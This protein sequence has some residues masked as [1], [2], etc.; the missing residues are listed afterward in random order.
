MRGQSSH[1]FWRPGQSIGV[2]VR[3]SVGLY[4]LRS[5]RRLRTGDEP[6][7]TAGKKTILFS[8]SGFFPSRFFPQLKNLKPKTGCPIGARQAEPAP[9]RTTSPFG[10]K[11]PLGLA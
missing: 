5:R 1:S 3:D 6:R 11:R 10:K 7:R 9:P 2:G 4:L 8:E